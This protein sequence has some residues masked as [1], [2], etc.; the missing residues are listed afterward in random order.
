M[1]EE[2]VFLWQ[3]SRSSRVARSAASYGHSVG[4]GSLRPP[5]QDLLPRPVVT[6]EAMKK[7][8]K[9]KSG[10]CYIVIVLIIVLIFVLSSALDGKLEV[11]VIFIFNCFYHCFD[12]CFY[13]SGTSAGEYSV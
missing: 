3:R 6:I 11:S 7:D 12:F 1:V 9:L 8:L 2:S 4:I 10:E 13:F 5:E